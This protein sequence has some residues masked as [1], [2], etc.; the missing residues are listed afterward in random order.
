MVSLICSTLFLTLKRVCWFNYI[1]QHGKLI[2]QNL[3]KFEHK[4]KTLNRFDCEL[5]LKCACIILYF[6]RIVFLSLKNKIHVELFFSN[7]I[8]I[9]NFS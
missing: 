7:M 5:M 2:K 8:E 1:V 9:D 6:L 3:F 4:E